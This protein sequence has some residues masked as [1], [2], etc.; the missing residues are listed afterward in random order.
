MKRYASPKEAGVFLWLTQA[1]GGP[2]FGAERVNEAL[3]RFNVPSE[4]RE[5]L[6]MFKNWG[7][8]V[9]QVL[10]RFSKP[11]DARAFLWLKRDFGAEKTDQ[12]LT[13]FPKPSDAREFLLA[14]KAAVDA[15]AGDFDG[16]R[17]SSKMERIEIG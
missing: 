10:K 7:V 12:A 15:R 3:Q 16:G 11:S 6:W 14:A 4:A 2:V 17:S 5:F 8:E 13:R 1:D 9:E